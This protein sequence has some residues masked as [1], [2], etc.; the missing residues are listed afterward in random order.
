MTLTQGG[1][2]QAID[3][4][5]LRS[6]VSDILGTTGTG[7]FGYGQVI[8]SDIPVVADT[9]IISAATTTTKQWVALYQD[10]TKIAN[11]QGGSSSTAIDTLATTYSNNIK[12]GSLIQYSDIH[13]IDT[14]LSIL[15]TNRLNIA[16]GQS[17][18]VT[19]LTSTRTTEWGSPVK[20]IVQHSFTVT[21][22]SYDAARYYFNAGGKIRFIPALVAAS[23]PQNNDWALML[24]S[25]GE[26]SFGYTSTSAYNTSTG[27]SRGTG[28]QIGFYD[29]TE[30]PQ[31][32]YT[33]GGN[34]ETVGAIYNLNDYTI[35]A[36]R[37]GAVLLFSV[38]FKDDDITKSNRPGAATYD[39]VTGTLTNNIKLTQ[40]TGSNV[41]IA[42]PSGLTTTELSA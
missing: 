24:A 1:L 32:V 6:R 39:K 42:L 14:T 2:I 16:A 23:T 25:I 22:A 7:D 31:Q 28:S 20:P 4:N 40:P 12:S 8:S 27:L 3:Y 18:D 11:H 15:E 30:S 37:S 34:A 38:Y 17:S 5:N 35:E 13:L 21:F 10:M 36:R 33:K 29:L 26:V 9:T 41:N 19:F